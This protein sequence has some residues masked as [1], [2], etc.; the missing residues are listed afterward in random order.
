MDLFTRADLRALLAE[1]AG[2]CVSL[3][4]PG[5]RGGAEADPI[6]WRVLLH[7]AE[8]RLTGAAHSATATARTPVETAVL[9]CPDL[10]ELARLRPDIGLLMY[11]NLAVGM[12]QKLKW[13]G[14]QVGERG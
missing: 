1:R 13:A 14:G 9:N 3:F 10:A 7:Q 4:L 2:P 11:R 12:G 5:H 8:Q 6:R